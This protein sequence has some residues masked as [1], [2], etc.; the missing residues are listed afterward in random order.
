MNQSG[1]KVYSDKGQGTRQ[2]RGSF[3]FVALLVLQVYVASAKPSD[4]LFRPLGGQQT[5]E[6]IDRCDLKWF[7]LPLD[8]FDFATTAETFQL[9]YFMCMEY[10]KG[11][12]GSLFVYLG[13]E[14][15]VTLYLNHTGLMWESAEMHGAGMVFLEHRYYG[16]SKPHRYSTERM[17]F[18]TT[19]QAMADYAR[20]ILQIKS[21]LQDESL[22]VICFGGSYGGM[23]A[24]YFRAKYPHI[25]SGAIAASAPIWTY[26]FEGYNSNSFARIVTKDA[27]ISSD[28]GAVCVK[29]VRRAF[30]VIDRIGKTNKVVEHWQKE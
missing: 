9:R 14:A 4:V 29:N 6:L 27:E 21:E 5:S 15:D 7:E 10:Y 3:L 18:L 23:L 2:T 11:H 22:P 28:D 20:V 16:E 30:E 25:T 24:A 13:N 19:E 8:H 17:E 12:N 1:R 26:F